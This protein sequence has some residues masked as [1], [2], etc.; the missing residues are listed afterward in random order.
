MLWLLVIQVGPGGR[1]WGLTEYGT[2]KAWGFVYIY[3]ASPHN[4][5]QSKGLNDSELTVR[6]D[7]KLGIGNSTYL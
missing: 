4:Q 3:N 1:E 6:E 7:S 2:T 5:L